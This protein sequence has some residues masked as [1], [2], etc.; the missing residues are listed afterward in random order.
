[1]SAAIDHGRALGLLLDPDRARAR[2]FLEF[3][4]DGKHAGH[5][6]GRFT[7]CLCIDEMVRDHLAMIRR[8]PVSG[9]N[10][11]CERARVS[12][13]NFHLHRFLACRDWSGACVQLTLTRV[14]LL[15]DLSIAS[16]IL[17][18]PTASSKVGAV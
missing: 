3:V 10:V 1:M 16:M 11:Q 7:G 17:W 15:A 9:K 4:D 14:P 12:D 6:A 18:T 2:P 13:R 5:A 8:H